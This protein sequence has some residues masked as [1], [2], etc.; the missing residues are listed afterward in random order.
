[1]IGQVL[2]CEYA[3]RGE[4]VTRAQLLQQELMTKPSSLPFDEVGEINLV[5]HVSCLLLLF[6][7]S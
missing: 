6:H 4:I 1:V 7:V 3:V 5:A 2:K